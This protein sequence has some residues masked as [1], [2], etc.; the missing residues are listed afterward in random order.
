MPRGSGGDGGPHAV[1]FVTRP[2][3]S[4]AIIAGA[5]FLAGGGFAGNLISQ[6]EG[7]A[8]TLALARATSASKSPASMLST[9]A[10]GLLSV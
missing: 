9:N 1:A 6:P 4:S 10:W 8:P 2:L 3:E 7:F 5:G